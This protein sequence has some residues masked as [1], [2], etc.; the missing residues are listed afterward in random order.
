MK[1]VQISSSDIIR[2]ICRSTCVLHILLSLKTQTLD[3][4][5][6]LLFFTL[7]NNE[8]KNT[9]FIFPIYLTF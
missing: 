9:W 3:T 2:Y 8:W 7:I 1:K 4:L 6:A 5:T